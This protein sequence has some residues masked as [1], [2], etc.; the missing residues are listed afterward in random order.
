MSLTFDFGQNWQEFSESKLDDQHFAEA[1]NSIEDLIGVEELQQKSL[2]D[3]GCGSGIFS[4]AAALLGARCVV[5]LDINAKS[6]HASHKNLTRFATY[7]TDEK[8]KFHVC[9]V[10]NLEAIQTFGAFDIVYAWGS[11]H[12]TGSMWEAIRNASQQVAPS[13]TFVLAIY[14]CHWTSPIWF[15]IKRIYNLS[16]RFVQNVLNYIFGAIIY[17]A[18]LLVVRK[19]PLQGERGMDFW[20]N[21][22]DW[23]G[24]Y[25]YEYASADEIVKFVEELGFTLKRIEPPRAPTGCNEFVF[26]K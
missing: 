3:I 21:V 1:K 13:G 9:D 10:L 12:H 16:P 4:I 23:L 5:G 24:G 18:V 19:N 2:L 15:Q 22:I 14:N 25:P 7:L 8:V 11:L 17:L 6:I 26:S 20:Y